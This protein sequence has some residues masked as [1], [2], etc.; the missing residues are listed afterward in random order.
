MTAFGRPGDC[1]AYAMRGFGPCPAD[2]VTGQ[3][4]GAVEIE[5]VTVAGA[6]N[7]ELENVPFHQQI[8]GR[9]APQR[10]VRAVRQIDGAGPGPLARQSLE[11]ARR[12]LRMTGAIAKK[13]RR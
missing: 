2:A 6:A 8:V 11:G 7:V 10:L 5:I 9:P 4:R 12:A 1:P 13:Q 3:N